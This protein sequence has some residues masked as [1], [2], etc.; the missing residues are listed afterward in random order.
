MENDNNYFKYETPYKETPET[1]EPNNKE[2]YKE[3]TNISQLSKHNIK[4][5][6]SN[7][8]EIKAKDFCFCPLCFL[9]MSG[10]AFITLISILISIENIDT[11]HKVVMIIATVITGPLTCI[12]L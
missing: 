4:Q 8:F 7:E 1:V 5:P 6:K 12:L 9:L 10:F 11:S 3:I 2:K